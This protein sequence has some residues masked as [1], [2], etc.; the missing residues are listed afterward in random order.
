MDSCSGFKTIYMYPPVDFLVQKVCKR[1]FGTLRNGR[2]SA[3][4]NRFDWL[5]EYSAENQSK[6]FKNALK[7]PFRHVPKT[8]SQTFRTKNQPGSSKK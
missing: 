1:V 7:R 5:S 3:F 6:R 8:L 2:F 4:L